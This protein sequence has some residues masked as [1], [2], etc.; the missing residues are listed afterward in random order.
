MPVL[1]PCRDGLEPPRAPRTEEENKALS[2]LEVMMENETA[3]TEVSIF[4]LLS[5]ISTMFGQNKVIML[6]TKYFA[7]KL[8]LTLF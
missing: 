4:S 1:R 7:A 2:A 6:K 3:E 8:D 5:I